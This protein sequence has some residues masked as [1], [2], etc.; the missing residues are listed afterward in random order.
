MS[1]G[2]SKRR[3]DKNLAQQ[4]D[5]NWDVDALLDNEDVDSAY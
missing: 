3:S 5:F 2:K 1:S 4:R